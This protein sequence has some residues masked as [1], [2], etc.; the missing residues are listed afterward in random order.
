MS[1]FVDEVR[2]FVRGGDGGDGCLS[3]RREAHVP[4][5][6]PDGGDGGEGGGVMLIADESTSSLLG[7]RDYPH[8]IGDNAKNGGSK[9]LAAKDIEPLMVKVP[10]GTQVRNLEKEIVADLTSHGD[11]F[12]AAYGGQGGRG[13][14][15]FLSNRLRAPAFCERGEK[16]Q[17][18]SYFLTLKLLADIALVGFP[19][20]GKS[21]LISVVSSSKPKI[22][23]YPFT[24]LT[25]NLGVVKSKDGSTFVVA[26]IP[27]LIEGAA[28][29]KGLGHQFLKHIERA[30]TLA[31]LIDLS[32]GVYRESDTG[33]SDSGDTDNNNESFVAKEYNILTKELQNYNPQLLQR[34]RLL[35]G[36]KKELSNESTI[37]EFNNFCEK[38][39]LR[40]IVISA[41]TNAN[42]AQCIEVMADI[43]KNTDTETRETESYVLHRPEPKGFLVTKNA[44][45]SYEVH[46][47]KARQSVNVSDIA[48]LDAVSFIQ[49]KL[50]K[51]GV[52]RALRKAGVVE[53][54]T[55]MI[56]DFVFEYFS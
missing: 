3:F 43:V 28:D 35:I 13:N 25:P 17:D 27:G 47:R 46:G 45:G 20:A 39:D 37:N 32:A 54:D 40:G 56:G 8:R 38:N 6:G 50:E 48:N 30:K 23:N 5:G 42:I 24:T 15:R 10:V 33:E 52:E 41:S 22:A 14:A 34:P 4:L 16:G 19:N 53:G 9:K 55:V 2:I 7:F 11:S 44:D 26:D 31:I 12:L 29:G 1:Q 51:I 21:T 18:T 49:K 36:T